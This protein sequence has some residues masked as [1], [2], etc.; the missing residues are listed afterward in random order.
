M[1]TSA[2]RAISQRYRADKQG[3]TDADA[4]AT[5][6]GG[7]KPKVVSTWAPE[8]PPKIS[9]TFAHHYAHHYVPANTLNRLQVH[10]KP[11]VDMGLIM[12]NKVPR[13]RCLPTGSTPGHYGFQS[14]H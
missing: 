7:R 12:I 11:L 13:T 8:R 14:L 1:A 2:R 5:S 9:T 3:K 10:R 6:C 4:D